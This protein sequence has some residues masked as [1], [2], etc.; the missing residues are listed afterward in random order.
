MSML[1][2]D[3]RR[4]DDHPGQKSRASCAGLISRTRTLR[5]SEDSSPS[6]PFSGQEQLQEVQCGSNQKTF[7]SQEGLSAGVVHHRDEV[8]GCPSKHAEVPGEVRIAYPLQHEERNATR[9][10]HPSTCKPQDA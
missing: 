5:G 3:G 6:S 8:T 2:R 10:C 1:F 4:G 9:I 7:V